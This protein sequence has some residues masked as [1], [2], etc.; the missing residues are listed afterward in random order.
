M[1][2]FASFFQKQTLHIKNQH[3]KQNIHKG[4]FVKSQQEHIQN[5][6]LHLKHMQKVQSQIYQQELQKNKVV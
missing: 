2:K 1:N 3:L 5:Q 4:G 6:K